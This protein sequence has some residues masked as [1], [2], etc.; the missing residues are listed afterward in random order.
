MAFVTEFV[1][2]LESADSHDSHAIRQLLNDYLA[3]NK[4]TSVLNFLVDYY[5]KTQSQRCLQVLVGIHEPYGKHLF[6]KLLDSLKGKE[7]LQTLKLVTHIVHKQPPW[8]HHIT[9]HR[10]L[11]HVLGIIKGDQEV[12]HTL[13]ANV[14][15]ISLMPMFPVQYG[16]SALADT[17]E[18]FS[19]LAAL[20]TRKPSHIYENHMVHLSL[21]LQALF[22][23]LYGMYP[24]NFLAYLRGFYGSQDHSRD[25]L[26]IYT[27][28]IRPLLQRTRLHP[29]LVT[30]SKEAE[31]GPSRWKKMRTYDILAECARHTLD[32]T[33]SIPETES[34]PST[35][36]LLEVGGSTGLL[37]TVPRI[38]L[39]ILAPMSEPVSQLAAG[40]TTCWSPA[41]PCGLA[42]SKSATLHVT[43]GPTPER[44]FDHLE[45][46]PPLDVA[47]EAT[48]EDIHAER[49]AR[50]P[51]ATAFR[52]PGC[53]EEGSLSN[54]NKAIPRELPDDSGEGRME[55]IETPFC[56]TTY[57][58]TAEPHNSVSELPEY[59]EE[60]EQQQQRQQSSMAELVQNMSRMRYFSHH[61]LG[62]H[63]STRHL[64]RCRSCPSLLDHAGHGSALQDTA[65]ENGDGSACLEEKTL[66]GDSPKADCG[67]CQ[68][69]GTYPPVQRTPD[70]AYGALLTLSLAPP[71]LQPVEKLSARTGDGAPPQRALTLAEM[72]PSELLEKHLQL[73]SENYLRRISPQQPYEESSG[74]APTAAEIQDLRGQCCLL[75]TE[76]LYERHRRD[77]HIERCRRLL[78]KAKKLQALEEQMSA[79]RDQ[80]LFQEKEIQA[81][82]A[83]I[84]DLRATANREKCMLEKCLEEQ[85]RVNGNLSTQNASLRCEKEETIALAT[86]LEAELKEKNKQLDS[87]TG[88]HLETNL[89]LQ[90]AQGHADVSRAYQQKVEALERELVTVGE[91]YQRLEARLSAQTPERRADQELKLISE[92][93]RK[94]VASTM[95]LLETKAG[96]LD[97]SMSRIKQLDM[98]LKKKDVEVTELKQI[99]ERMNA[100]HK[101]EMESKRRRINA[102][103]NICQRMEV[104]IL[105]LRHAVEQKRESTS[106]ASGAFDDICATMDIDESSPTVD[107]AGILGSYT[108][109]TDL[110]PVSDMLKDA[111]AAAAAQAADSSQDGSEDDRAVKTSNANSE[112]EADVSGTAGED[113]FEHLEQAVLGD[114]EQL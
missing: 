67:T 101:E 47:V 99:L 36:T 41:E 25:N 69:Q 16:L 103:V 3:S 77:I 90:T 110:T 54:Q 68:E 9:G 21:G 94:E 102:L 80:L 106:E 98:A 112:S 1:S 35:A 27:K 109:N 11:S 65:K 73:T 82:N 42:R 32:S 93:A 29:L 44:S 15:I 26:V 7:R 12:T 66:N 18:A 4:D 64:G 28:T 31:L 89:E 38:S 30:A 87:A 59:E 17:F 20:C 13:L 85:K 88:L 91:M 100:C 75:Y 52:D 14:I 48:P 33:E 61:L 104:H 45:S 57:T 111:E 96:H 34:S 63:T 113:S 10:I 81:L 83:V 40:A 84:E 24:C 60:F 95:H 51:A 53:K 8:L 6:D 76:L 114:I 92:A 39:D 74:D 5:L 46:S 58:L 107:P 56:S 22:Q 23:K 62:Y 71:L 78:A 105:E 70:D 97:A 86:K 72:S 49:G 108:S 19:S 37:S 43:R 2:A 55:Q 79:Y 50:L